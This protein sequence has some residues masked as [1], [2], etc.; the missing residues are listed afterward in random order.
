MILDLKKGHLKDHI[1]SFLDHFWN[2]KIF[3]LLALLLHFCLF[4]G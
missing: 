1:I 2:S 4:C 3:L